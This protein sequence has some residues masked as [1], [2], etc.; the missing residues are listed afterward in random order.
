MVSARWGPGRGR[1]ASV[2]IPRLS[3]APRDGSEAASFRKIRKQ[4]S[5]LQAPPRAGAEFGIGRRWLTASGFP[6][7]VGRSGGRRTPSP[8][9]VESRAIWAD[10]DQLARGRALAGREERRGG[11]T[12]VRTGQSVW[13][14]D[15]EKKTES[16]ET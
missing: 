3:A 11:Q 9:T 10:F 12:V 5:M 16:K 13:W 4:S 6:R 15:N 14:R 8:M 1:P 7:Y 2:N